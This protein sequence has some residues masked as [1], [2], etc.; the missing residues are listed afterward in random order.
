VVVLFTIE[1]LDPLGFLGS[2]V[3]LGPLGSL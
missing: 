1:A 3:A 2:F